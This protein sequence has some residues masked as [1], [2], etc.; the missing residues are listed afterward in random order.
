MSTSIVG[1]ERLELVATPAPREIW[2]AVV[3]ADPEALPS[4]TPEWVDALPTEW[5]D[6]SRLYTTVDGRNVV[7]AMVRNRRWRH[8]VHIAG[9]YPRGLGY[10]GVVAEGGVTTAESLY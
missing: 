2:S 9:S 7:V 4:Q 8:L 6:V 5:V 10:G 1:R 3:G